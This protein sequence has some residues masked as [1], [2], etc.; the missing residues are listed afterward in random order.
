MLFIRRTK[1]INQ[2][3]SHCQLLRWVGLV[4][5]LTQDNPERAIL[6]CT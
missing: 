2:A 1:L 6:L 5:F 3:Y 4:Y